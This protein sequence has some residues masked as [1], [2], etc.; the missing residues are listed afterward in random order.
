MES[1]IY[2]NIWE[3]IMIFFWLHVRLQR[4]HGFQVRPRSG[5]VNGLEDEAAVFLVAGGVEKEIAERRVEQ[6]AVDRGSRQVDLKIVYSV[7]YSNCCIWQTLGYLLDTHVDPIF[8]DSSDWV[9]FL[10]TFNH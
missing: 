3:M 4:W 2:Q 8:Y 9:T 7:K 6:V 10:I 1:L 5:V